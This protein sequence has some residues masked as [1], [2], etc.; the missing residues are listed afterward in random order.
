[1]CY[2]YLLPC[3]NT[4]GGITDTIWKV[5]G[6]QSAKLKPEAEQLIGQYE[7]RLRCIERSGFSGISGE[8]V[9]ALCVEFERELS[10]LKSKKG[11]NLPKKTRSSIKEH[12]LQMI[13][14]CRDLLRIGE[15]MKEACR[16][17]RETKQ[18]NFC[19]YREIGDM[20]II[21][22]QLFDRTQGNTNISE[23]MKQTLSQKFNTQ[24]QEITN[25]FIDTCLPGE[26]RDS[27]QLI[28]RTLAEPEL[29]SLPTLVMWKETARKKIE[30]IQLQK[31]VYPQMI[32]DN[33]VNKY[34]LLNS[35]ARL[36]TF[37]RSA[38]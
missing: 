3:I 8:R 5:M 31:T 1:M 36:L 14:L 38:A 28:E 26:F 18:A 16:M 12:Y 30:K 24:M 34:S 27:I 13:Q 25:V 10:E 4:S 22:N 6:Q 21:A 29:Y 19:G 20:L 17:V 35:K 9:G 32:L 15:L 33:I 7:Q 23:Y 11:A 2:T 37:H